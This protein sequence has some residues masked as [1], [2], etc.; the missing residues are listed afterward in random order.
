M[1]KNVY[2]E[3]GLVL[4]RSVHVSVVSFRIGFLNFSSMPHGLIPSDNGGQQ[5]MFSAC[6]SR[7]LKLQVSFRYR[8]C[9]G[10]TSMREK[11]V[12]DHP[13]C[14]STLSCMYRHG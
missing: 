14:G 4:S 8:A 2:C 12:K 9:S 11:A 6:R 3:S 5:R 1:I 13:S 7:Y 10:R